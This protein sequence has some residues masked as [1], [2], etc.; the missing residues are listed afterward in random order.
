[1]LI[2]WS[3]GVIIRAASQEDADQIDTIESLSPSPWSRSQI[4]AELDYAQG[5][6]LVAHRQNGGIIGW[7]CAR[8]IPP[9]AELLKVATASAYKRK[10]VAT[11]L[12]EDLFSQC[13]SRGC[14]KIYLEVRQHN[15]TA[16][17]LYDKLGFTVQ[18]L[19]K[20]YY[21]NP[22]DN[23]VILSKDI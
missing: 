19:R 7:C 15:K 13:S 1:M 4:N 3:D 10:G 5:I 9:E 18:A 17:N 22:H 21:H 20:N 6:Q 16:L 8:L 23:G 14:S 2:Q 12:L 11:L